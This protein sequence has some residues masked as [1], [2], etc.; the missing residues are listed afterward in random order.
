ML[1]AAKSPAQQEARQ[2]VVLVVEDEVLIRSAVAEYLRTPGNLVVEAA[3][4]AEAVAVFAAGV[5]I[6]VVFSDIQTPG[7]MDGL[8]LARW[9]Y[10]HYPG[11]HVVLTSGNSDAARATEVARLLFPKP[12]RTAEV[13]MRIRLLLAE[14]LP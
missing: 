13:A 2:P 11:I 9:V 10:H 8:S 3:N 4:A 12:Y 6:D 1:S 7:T 14:V 5:P